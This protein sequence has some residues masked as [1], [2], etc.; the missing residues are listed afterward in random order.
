[1]NTKLTLSLS[2]EI[3]EE[4]KSYA[5]SKGISLSKVVEDVLKEIVHTDMKNSPDEQNMHPT[6][7]K[8]SGSLS[9][10]KH[11]NLNYKQLKE[12]HLKNK[13]K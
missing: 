12:L 11:K 4:A 2:K 7:K 6:L 13:L 10:M 5:K 8:L 3:I 1:M 9:N